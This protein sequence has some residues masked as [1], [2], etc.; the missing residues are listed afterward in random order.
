MATDPA[1][2]A[3]AKAAA[4]KRRTDWVA[5]RQRRLVAAKGKTK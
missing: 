4:D 5:E 1:L 3:K 2:A